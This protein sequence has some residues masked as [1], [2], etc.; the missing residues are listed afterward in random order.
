MLERIENKL[1]NQTTASNSRSSGIANLRSMNQVIPRLPHPT[2]TLSNFANQSQSV[3]NLV[4]L[5]GSQH[6]I[7]DAFK[8]LRFLLLLKFRC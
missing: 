3:F 5:G 7:F 4:G 6:G 8:F 2:S 1:P